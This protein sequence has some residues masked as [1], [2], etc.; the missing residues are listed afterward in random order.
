M[1]YVQERSFIT[2][3]SQKD[4]LS[5]CGDPDIEHLSCD[6]EEDGR[7]LYP[8]NPCAFQ[9]IFFTGIEIWSKLYMHMHA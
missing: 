9:N 2:N 3:M 1:E 8:Q 5:Q 7:T 4:V 6:I